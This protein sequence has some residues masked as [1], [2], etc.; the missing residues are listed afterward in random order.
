MKQ[1]YIFLFRGVDKIKNLAIMIC[2]ETGIFHRRKSSELNSARH[3]LFY[4]RWGSDSGT[5]IKI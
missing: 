2:E 4:F 5:E 3:R 1:K